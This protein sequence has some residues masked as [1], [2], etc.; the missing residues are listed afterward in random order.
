MARW[1]K[2]LIAAALLIAVLIVALY[3]FLALYD[4]NKL[5][6]MIAKAVK[7]A[8]GRELTLAGNVDFELGLRP[9][10]VVEKVSFQNAS[11]SAT[12]N[13]AQVKRLEV[14]IAVLPIITGKFDFAR[15]V[16]VEPAVI[17]EFNDS[18]TSNFAFDTSSGQTDE[19]ATPPPPLI[20]SHALIEN[21]R[22]TFNTPARIL[23]SRSEST[24]SKLKYPGLTTPCS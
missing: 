18:G 20:F 7:D 10:L 12:P 5:K 8:T 4:F 24:A 22:F 19:S 11:W 16:L 15:L 1:K 6:P 9:T 23:I 14:Q 13:L 21:G 3:A 2:I 17:V